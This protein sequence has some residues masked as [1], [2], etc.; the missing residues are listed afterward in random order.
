MHTIFLK[1][2]TP[3][4]FFSDLTLFRVGFLLLPHLY[5]THLSYYFFVSLFLPILLCVK[6]KNKYLKILQLLEEAEAGV[7]LPFPI[8]L[9][10]RLGC[11]VIIRNEAKTALRVD[12]E[13][14]MP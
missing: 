13:D 9:K 3:F 4:F 11:I 1:P 7:P 8:H 14:V 10:N 12:N 2:L 5:H 6:R